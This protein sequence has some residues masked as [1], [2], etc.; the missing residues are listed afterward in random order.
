MVP[1]TSIWGGMSPFLLA[2][3]R[4][5]QL[6]VLGPKLK[7]GPF[8]QCSLKFCLDHEQTLTKVKVGAISFLFLFFIIYLYC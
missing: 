5:M 8:A 6:R 7:S 3:L 2:S 4:L 1:F